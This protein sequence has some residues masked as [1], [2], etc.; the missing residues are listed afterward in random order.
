MNDCF[1]RSCFLFSYYS[2][3]HIKDCEKA[4]KG[5]MRGYRGGKENISGTRLQKGLF[6]FPFPCCDDVAFYTSA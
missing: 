2:I 4:A 3:T 5:S 6:T 1:F